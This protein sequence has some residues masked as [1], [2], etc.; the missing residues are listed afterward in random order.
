[1]NANEVISNRAIEMLGAQLGSKNAGPPER[2]RQQQPVVQRQLPDR[3]AHRGGRAGP[4]RA[5]LP[6]LEHLLAALQAKADGIRRHHQDRPHPSPG[7]DAAH[8][9][10]GVLRLRPRRSATASSGSSDPAAAV[11]ARAGRHRGRHRPQRCRA[12]PSFRRGSGARSPACRSSPRRTSSRRWRPRTP[13]S[14]CR[15]ALNVL[16]VSLPRSPTTSACS[17]RGRAAARRAAPAGERAGLVDHAG[18]GQPD[19]VRGH[20][21]G[22][23][24]GVRQSRRDHDRRR[25]RP[26]RAQRV[27]AGDH[28]QPA[29]VDPAAGGRGAQLHR[30]LRGRDRGRSSGSTSCCTA[31]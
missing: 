30:Q 27:Q 28:L 5:A 25:D 16:A 9:R 26:L 10:P 29:A 18:Q 12:S 20:D 14:S 13:R 23:R 22:V 2:P 3:D 19:P 24:P 6:A 8:P 31:R 7:R 1:M 21:H 17:A 4:A 15:G 11:R